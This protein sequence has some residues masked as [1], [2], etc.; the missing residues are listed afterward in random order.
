MTKCLVLIV[1]LA[2]LALLFQQF[3]IMAFLGNF[4]KPA[5]QRL[6]ENLCVSSVQESL[7]NKSAHATFCSIIDC[8]HYY[9]LDNYYSAIREF[10]LLLILVIIALLVPYLS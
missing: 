2:M 10:Q 6:H 5:K 8:V 4:P 9:I 7:F 1:F 3:V